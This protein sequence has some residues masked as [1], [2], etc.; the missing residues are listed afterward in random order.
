MILKGVLKTKY[1]TESIIQWVY[2]DLIF[3]EI[4]NIVIEYLIWN[5]T[6]FYYQEIY[7]SL[8]QISLWAAIGISY[9]PYKWIRFIFQVTN[10]NI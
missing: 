7:K 8:V 4:K 1:Y 6:T 10:E 5:I 9:Q 3:D 2:C